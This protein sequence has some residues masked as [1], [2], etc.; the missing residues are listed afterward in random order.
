M[1][2]V[3]FTA[4]RVNGFTCPPG[5]SQAFLWDA[6][7]PGLGLRVTPNGRPSYIFQ[8]VY[9]GKDVRI[10]IGSPSAWSIADAR[11]KAR[12]LQRLIDEGRDPRDLKRKHLADQEAKAAAT[13][14]QQVLVSEAWDAYLVD[15]RSM[16]GDRHYADHVAM[17]KAGGTPA[18][19]GTRGQK[20]TVAGPLHCL[21]S[22]PLRDLTPERISEW[23]AAEAK[24][25]PTVARLA[26]RILRAF[27]GWC[28]EQE[29]Y[30]AL[31]TEGNPAKS[32]KT[33]ETL[34]RPGVKKDALQ[35]EQLKAWFAGVR[36]I[37]NRVTSA[38]LQ[39][40]LLT[41][42]RPGE[43]LQMR[44]IDVDF[45]W[46]SIVIRDKIEGERLIPMT[47]Y[48]CMLLQDLPRRNQWVFASVR[49]LD[50][51]EK[52][53][54][55]RARKAQQLGI[56]APIGD[57]IETSESGHIAP[58]NHAAVRVCNQAGI[59]PVTLHG[60]RR[61]YGTLAEWVEV[62]AGIVAQLQGHKPSATA[63]KHY[64]ARPLDLLRLWAD[65]IEAWILDQADI[66]VPDS[67][68]AHGR[69]AIVT[70]N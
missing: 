4:G 33:R 67:A 1:A 18:N 2:K 9:A 58:P 59:P 38:Y 13:K 22:L 46:R 65:K 27:L 14:L 34:G 63:E 62:P 12:E 50:Q 66:Q 57:V 11:A 45:K 30:K 8:G 10:T 47:G 41:G 5:K 64:R 32:R 51:G 29:Q 68:Q 25:R 55:R 49:N 17:A 20:A 21:M 15:R 69:L 37:S 39:T 61:S 42:A 35:R 48:V 70:S 36:S 44:W 26:W 40:L 7:A 23:A 56:H 16:W 54:A 19:R 28:A 24:T 43:V 6:N 60:L 53:T 52:N 3:S 31:L